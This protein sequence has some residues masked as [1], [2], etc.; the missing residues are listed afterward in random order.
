MAERTKAGDGNVKIL[1]PGT[2][3]QGFAGSGEQREGARRAPG[4][5]KSG[6]GNVKILLPETELQG[7]AGSGEQREGA[8]G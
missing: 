6:G 7:F 4:R 5:F 2:E 1:L 8:A 3:L